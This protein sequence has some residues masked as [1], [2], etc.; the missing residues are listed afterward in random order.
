MFSPARGCVQS[1]DF[2][3]ATCLDCSRRVFWSFC[4]I[5]I[6]TVCMY[7]LICVDIERW[8]LWLSALVY[9][10]QVFCVSCALL[11]NLI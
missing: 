7:I 8:K 1:G 6:R 2:R 3:P 4:L 5:C 9:L 11:I 10:R